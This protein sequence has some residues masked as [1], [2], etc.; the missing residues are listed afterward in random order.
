MGSS[1]NNDVNNI[2]RRAANKKATPPVLSNPPQHAC[3]PP[4]AGHD[5]LADDPPPL[6]EVRPGVVPAQG[7]VV[8]PAVAV[9]AA[10]VLAAVAVV[11]QA[12]VQL[13][14]GV[15]LQ[16]TQR[17]GIHSDYITQNAMQH[18]DSL[19]LWDAEA[20]SHRGRGTEDWGVFWVM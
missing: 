17:P 20:G 5:D 1:T 19:R 15:A 11:V 7:F 3:D 18:W 4:I 6:V 8:A 12:V 2:E 13:D 14:P 16:R 9:P 10:A